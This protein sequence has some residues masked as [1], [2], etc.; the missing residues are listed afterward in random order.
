M[1]LKENEHCEVQIS[2]L[3][4]LFYIPTRIYTVD[5]NIIATI[6]MRNHFCY[7]LKILI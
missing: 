3:I 7:P 5:E 4:R 6:K 1:L 2:S